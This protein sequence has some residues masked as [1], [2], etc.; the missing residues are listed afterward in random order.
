MNHI[1]EEFYNPI[2]IIGFKGHP[3]NRFFAS[4]YINGK[5]KYTNGFGEIIHCDNIH[6]A[7]KYGYESLILAMKEDNTYYRI[8]KYSNTLDEFVKKRYFKNHI[9]RKLYSFYLWIGKLF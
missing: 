7:Y 5:E 2:L 3:V 1:N 4:V 9:K 8:E 6:S